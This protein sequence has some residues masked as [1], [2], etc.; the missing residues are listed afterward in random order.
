MPSWWDDR[1]RAQAFHLGDDFGR[2]IAFVRDHGF[3]VLAFQQ[4][5]GLGIFR[6]LSG[7]DAEVHRQPQFVGQ[8]VNFGAQST[9]GTPQSRVFGAPFLRPAAAC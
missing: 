5:D 4:I 6:S 9:S 1:D 8:Q 2:V 3:S 7:R